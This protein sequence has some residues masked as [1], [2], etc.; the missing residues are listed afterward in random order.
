MNDLWKTELSEQETED[1]ISK[2]A[3]EIKK[4]KLQVPAMLL[5]EMHKPLSFISSQAAI[6]FSPF[7]VPFLGFDGVNN[8]SRL[9]ADRDNVERLLRR[10]EEE[11]EGENPSEGTPSTDSED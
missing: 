2:A 10:L 6:V 8:Y 9:F 4:R 5:F 1:L 11:Q 7:L 3:N